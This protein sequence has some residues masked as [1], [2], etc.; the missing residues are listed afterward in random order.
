MSSQFQ[1]K[2]E[3]ALRIKNDKTLLTKRLREAKGVLK[4]IY[5]K[6]FSKNKID[7]ENACMISDDG[8][9]KLQWILRSK[10]DKPE[11]YNNQQTN[12]GLVV[13]EHV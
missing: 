13:L 10:P 6:R 9:L 7:F 5:K 2:V 4:D 8:A 11:S 12:R 3:Q 1:K